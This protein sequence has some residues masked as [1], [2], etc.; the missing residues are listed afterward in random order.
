M[1]DENYIVQDGNQTTSLMVGGGNNLVP[2]QEASP[3]DEI[4]RI[5]QEFLMADLIKEVGR[6]RIWRMKDT[7]SW[8]LV[9]DEVTGELRYET[10]E[11]F[12]SDM[13]KILQCGRTHLFDRMRIY[14]Q[15]QWLGYTHEEMLRMMA[16]APSLYYRFLTKAIMWDA[17]LQS[18][19]V[20]KIPETYSMSNADAKDHVRDIVG[21][22]D[23]FDSTHQALKYVSETVLVEPQL[24]IIYDGDVLKCIYYNQEED[25]NGEVQVVDYDEAMFYPNKDVPDWVHEKLEAAFKRIRNG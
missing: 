2:P 20:I 8:K 23:S 25:A 13:S 7:G 1:S 19:T 6:F 16:T 4:E 14:D 24:E 17:K 12:I 15:L 11:Q 9:V 5:S 21:K 3:N 22:L 10:W 18:P